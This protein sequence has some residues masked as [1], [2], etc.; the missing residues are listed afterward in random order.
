[1]AKVPKVKVKQRST[2]IHSRAHRRAASPERTLNN[3]K[4]KPIPSKASSSK[5][6]DAADSWLYAA[7]ST[8]V[9]KKAPKAKKLTR[10]Q[11]VRQLKA[12][13]HADRNVDKLE[14]KVQ[15]SKARSNRV[16][17]RAKQWEDVNGVKTAAAVEGKV[18]KAPEE[19]KV[20]AMEGVEEDEVVE[21]RA[22]MVGAD[23]TAGLGE[24]RAFEDE[25]ARQPVEAG[26]ADIDVDEIG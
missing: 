21:P 20:S 3:N 11:R 18:V 7:K 1:M 14:K 16:Q 19:G 23:A 10:Q 15:D 5:D 2:S 9:H 24:G 6:D 13:E 17:A 4:P 22:E 25:D 8:G 12:L 26:A